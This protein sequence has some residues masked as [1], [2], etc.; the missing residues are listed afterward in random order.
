MRAARVPAKPLAQRWAAPLAIVA[1]AALYLAFPPVGWWPLAPVGV[2]AFTAALHARS[3]RGGFL[4]GLL[5]GAV[6]FVPL[7]DWSQFAG[8][9]AWLLLA[10][11][12]A[13][14]VGLL[15]A[16][17]TLVFRLPGWPLW[18]GALWVGVEAIRGRVPF[19]GFTW[20]RL[21][22]SQPQTA[23]TGWASLGGAPLV[24]FAVAL[25]GAALAALWLELR[26]ADRPVLLAVAV[27]GVVAP[28]V[29]TPARTA[30]RPVDTIRVAAV[31]GNVPRL[32]LDA[33]SQARQVLVNHADATA[34]LVPTDDGQRPD[35]I[36]WPENSSDFDPFNDAP[37]RS[38]ITDAVRRAGIPILVGAILDGPGVKI[39]NAGILWRPDSGPG[40][41]Y[42]K[43][44]PVPFGEYIPLR[45]FLTPYFGRLAL[46]PHD[47]A[48]GNTVGIFPLPTRNGSFGDVICFEV[49]YDDLM[50][51]VVRAGARFI[52]VQTNNA[53]F[54]R[55]AETHQQLAIARLRAVEHRRA[56]VVSATSGVTAVIS[57]DGTVLDSTSVFTRDVVLA[58][59]ALPAP[60]VRTVADRVGAGPEWTLV[61]LATAAVIAGVAIGRRE[62]RPVEAID[63]EPD[64]VLA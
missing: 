48:R 62:R 39:R 1:G 11:G 28:I 46:V 4:L 55:L 54:E 52:V 32:G 36:I 15:G 43:R 2:A 22:F 9:N 45:R 59:L 10:V 44:H 38:I 19:G 37:A 50:R 8:T 42:V 56:V 30:P 7:L 23:F 27:V 29:A 3:A 16:L 60:G 41:I 5:T 13:I 26:S 57:A 51:D 33:F 58:D 25:S 63:T 6:F 64:A 34:A 20:G 47:Q 12:M 35:L 18:A 14:Y 49:A 24:S 40:E 17:T 31:Q 53:S 61:A 21:A